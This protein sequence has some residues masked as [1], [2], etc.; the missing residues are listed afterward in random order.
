MHG[1]SQR[2]RQFCS[3]QQTHLCHQRRRRLALVLVSPGT[4]TPLP[5]LVPPSTPVKS[6]FFLSLQ[7]AKIYVAA[8]HL[9]VEPGRRVPKR[10]F[11][12]L[13]RSPDMTLSRMLARHKNEVFRWFEECIADDPIASAAATNDKGRQQQQTGVGTARGL[14]VEKVGGLPAVIIESQK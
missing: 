5:P 8:N 7:T 13:I 9:A 3:R 4:L 1:P 11:G 10:K 2:N 6:D 14:G 12:T